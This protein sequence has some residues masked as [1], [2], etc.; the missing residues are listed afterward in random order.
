MIWLGGGEMNFLFYLSVLSLVYVAKVDAVYIHEET[1]PTGTFWNLLMNNTM[2]RHV[3]RKHRG[4]DFGRKSGDDKTVRSDSWRADILFKY[5]GIY[6]DT[7]V[8]FTKPLDHRLRG[9]DAVA[10]LEVNSWNGFPHVIQSGVL[11]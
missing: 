5:G 3:F 6:I 4:A 8:L 10:S 1:P 9:Y 7:D 11:M 2:V